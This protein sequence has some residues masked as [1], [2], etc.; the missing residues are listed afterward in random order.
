MRT[1]NDRRYC[2]AVGFGAV[3]GAGAGSLAMIESTTL[4]IRSA[5][6]FS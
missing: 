3:A 2:P 5:L 4:T 1:R 6:M